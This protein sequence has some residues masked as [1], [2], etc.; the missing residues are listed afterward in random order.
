LVIKVT[1]PYLSKNS[2]Q[3]VKDLHGEFQI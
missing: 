2:K 3:I 1:E